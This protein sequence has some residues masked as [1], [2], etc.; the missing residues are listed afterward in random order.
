[1]LPEG[2]VFDEVKCGTQE[3]MNGSD[4]FRFFWII[5]ESGGL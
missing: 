4:N 1:M 5:L 3:Q 2:P